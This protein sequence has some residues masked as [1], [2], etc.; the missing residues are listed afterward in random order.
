MEQCQSLKVLSLAN[1]EMDENYCRVLGT[2]SR[3]GLEIVLDDCKITS[4]GASA[5]GEVLGRNQGPTKLDRCYIDNVVLANGLRENSRL[6]SLKPRL[7][8]SPE[9][10]NREF[11]AIS[12]ALRE[13]K[14]L[15][16]LDLCYR[17]AMND[18]TWG[19]I[20]DSL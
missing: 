19:V 16:D 6:K 12:D 20:C 9:D 11:H 17:F 8:D 10:G 1:L 15:V 5:L 7:S 18:E 13:N 14:G 3:P 2:Y 4:A